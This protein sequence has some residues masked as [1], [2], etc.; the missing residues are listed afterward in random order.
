MS[1]A[2]VF[3]S[4]AYDGLGRRAQKTINSLLTQFHYDGLDIVRESG[5]AGD[6]SYLRTLNLDEPLARTDLN[7]NM[8]A[9]YLTDA[10]GSSL[11]LS[12]TGGG[13]TTIYSYGPF[14]QTSV[15]GSSSSNPIQ[16]TG[17]E[18]DPTRLYFYRS[19]Y[20]YPDLGRFI[21]EDPNGFIGTASLY[22]YT[23]IQSHSSS[24]SSRPIAGKNGEATNRRRGST[25]PGHR[26]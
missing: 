16:F 12:D 21:S 6:A 20:L 2:S 11:V 17:R 23:G 1:G 22:G 26:T 15:S 9:Y 10:Q 5:G 7:M 18:A 13:N 4:F 19:R 8:I 24:R 25:H 3:A 14:G